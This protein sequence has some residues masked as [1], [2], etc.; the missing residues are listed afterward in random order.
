MTKLH[1]VII[2]SVLTAFTCVEAGAVNIKDFGASGNVKVNSTAAFKKAIASGVKDIYVPAGSYLIGPESVT[3]PADVYLHGDGNASKLI[4]AANT[5]TVFTLCK[6]SRISRLSFDGI[7]GK[8]GS[9]GDGIIMLPPKTDMVVI[10]SVSFTGTNRPCIVTD[11][12]DDLIIRDC[13]FRNVNQAI[14]LQFSNRVRVQDNTVINAK[15]HGIQ[16]WGNWN[17]EA[18]QSDNLII[19]GNYV[20]DGGGGA[21]WGAGAR[22]V[23]VS[24]NIVDGA[25]DVG[26]DLEWCDDSV[27]SGNVVSNAENGCIS[28]FFAC[29]GVSITGNTVNN[30]R[31]ITDPKPGWYARAGIWLTYPNRESFKGD[32][33]HRDITIAGNTI[34]GGEGD[35]RAIWVGAESDNVILGNNTIN[36]SAIWSGGGTSPMKI[37]SDNTVIK[38]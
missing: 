35:R 16:F 9:V 15:V 23:V 37:I 38:K 14:S 11:H 3:I 17:W 19:T 18:K 2:L 28:L 6:G 10:E 21:I 26:I 30:N 7:K 24:N 27:I 25:T 8:P 4:L 22:N 12:A 5:G 1:T 29:R 31:K 34:T 33:G 36:G 13:H 32:N 20:K